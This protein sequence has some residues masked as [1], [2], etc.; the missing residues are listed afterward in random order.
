MRFFSVPSPAPRALD[1]LVVAILPS[2]RVT[3]ISFLAGF[4]HANFLAV[5][6]RSNG[7]SFCSW[8]RRT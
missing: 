5:I 7:F 4:G 1:S 2:V 3:A 6:R 8:Q